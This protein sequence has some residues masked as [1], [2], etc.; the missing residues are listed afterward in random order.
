MAISKAYVKLLGGEIW[1]E[2]NIDQGAIFYFTIPYPD[3]I[4][5]KEQLKAMPE[6]VILN[7]GKLKILIA[8]DDEASQMLLEIIITPLASESFYAFTGKRSR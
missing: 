2:R 1:I 5:E 6:E 3:V 8:E 7:H 4:K